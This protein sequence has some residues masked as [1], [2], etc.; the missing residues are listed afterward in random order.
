MH[1][2]LR[3]RLGLAHLVTR[4]QGCLVLALASP[5]TPTPYPFPRYP[6][7][8]RFFTQCINS[9]LFFALLTA[10]HGVCNKV[11]AWAQ[12]PT[13]RESMG[14][15]AF[16]SSALPESWWHFQ[17]LG[18]CLDHRGVHLGLAARVEVP[19]PLCDV[20]VGSCAA[21]APAPAWRVP[22]LG[23]SRRGLG[24]SF[25]SLA[26][27]GQGRQSIRLHVTRTWCLCPWDSNHCVA[28]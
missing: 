6:G 4:S 11:Q 22:W 9:M 24:G 1:K 2:S 7:D 12:V 14:P 15:E 5:G 10:L 21:A 28:P 20:L 25:C 16:W 13:L 8:A 3:P 27:W 23:P 19:C 18:T 26:F 17:G